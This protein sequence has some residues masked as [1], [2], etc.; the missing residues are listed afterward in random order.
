MFLILTVGCVK[1]SANEVLFLLAD[2]KG[3]VLFDVGLHTVESKARITLV[4]THMAVL[5]PPTINRD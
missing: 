2:K 4:L 1:M 3:F 5:R